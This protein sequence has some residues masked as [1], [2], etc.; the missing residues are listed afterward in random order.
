MTDKITFSNQLSHIEHKYIGTGNA[1]TTKW[2]WANHIQRDTLNSHIQNP[3]R[4]NY[5]AICENKP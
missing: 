1:E 3:S 5:F 2:E 4:L